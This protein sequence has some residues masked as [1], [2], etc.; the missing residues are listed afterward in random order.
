MLRLLRSS[1]LQ[2][3]P[4]KIAFPMQVASPRP[5]QVEESRSQLQNRTVLLRRVLSLLDRDEPVVDMTSKVLEQLV[6]LPLEDEKT[7][8]K[9]T[10]FFQALQADPEPEP[11]SSFLSYDYAES[12]NEAETQDAAYDYVE[13]VEDEQHTE[14]NDVNLKQHVM[15]QLDLMC[16][17]EE[18]RRYATKRLAEVQCD[19]KQFRLEKMIMMRRKR[20][21][22]AALKQGSRLAFA[23]QSLKHQTMED[24]SLKRQSFQKMKTRGRRAQS[25]ETFKSKYDAFEA[26]KRSRSMS[27]AN[28]RMKRQVFDRLCGFDEDDASSL[29][30]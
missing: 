19:Y 27:A 15:E 29:H 5:S 12:M 10:A 22:F 16:E 25:V 9:I 8:A 21:A 18:M 24:K 11:C 3:P 30:H 14:L 20:Q 17:N 1:E 2:Q 28:T 4:R 13:F 26:L 23:F 7:R 6:A